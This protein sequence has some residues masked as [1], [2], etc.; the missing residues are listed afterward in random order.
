MRSIIEAM[1]ASVAD[2]VARGGDD[3]YI[4]PIGDPA[5]DIE[6]AKI[7]AKDVRRS[8]LQQ[9]TDPKKRVSARAGVYEVIE[10]VAA[11]HGVELPSDFE[12]TDEDVDE[13]ILAGMFDAM[14][15]RMKESKE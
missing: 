8:A 7:K 5:T 6:S 15:Q 4:L 11:E 3:D 1:K 10:S 13:F 14:E 9:L 2:G 12:L